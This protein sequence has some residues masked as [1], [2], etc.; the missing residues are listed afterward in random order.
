MGSL[1]MT[2][3]LGLSVGSIAHTTYVLTGKSIDSSLRDPLL[4][5]LFVIGSSSRRSSLATMR[6]WRSEQ[7]GG[8]GCG[9]SS[10]T[11]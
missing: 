11:L 4:P 8:G 7:R 1:I 2:Y 6:V 9:H 5:W 10:L 3:L